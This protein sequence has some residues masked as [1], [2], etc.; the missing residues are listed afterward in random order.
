MDYRWLF[1]FLLI[2]ADYLIYPNKKQSSG[3]LFHHTLFINLA[4]N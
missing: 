2:I 4:I 3:A 1:V